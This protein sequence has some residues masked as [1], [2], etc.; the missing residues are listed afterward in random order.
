MVH[1]QTIC[2]LINV[3]WVSCYINM[4][5]K[6]LFTRFFLG[7]SLF[8]LMLFGVVINSARA[9]L[10]LEL[11]DLNLPDLGD[12][13]VFSLSHSEERKR[14]LE[15]LRS[16]RSSGSL[17]EDPEIN[18]WIRSLG[19]RLAARAPQTGNP[20]Y[21][22]VSKDKSINAFAT[23]GGVVLI[24]AGLIIRTDTESELAA[25]LSHE[26]AHVTQRHIARMIAKSKEDTFGRSA[27]I[28]AGI[29]AG[30]QNPEVGQAIIS[31][32]IAAGIQQQ[33]TFN[34][35]A[36]SEADRVG[37]R[38]LASSGFNPLGMPGF[39]EKLEQLS[40]DK[41]SE[42]TEYLRTHPLPHKRVV[43]T[44]FR[45]N[46]IGNRPVKDSANY[47]YMREKVRALVR[48]GSPAASSIPSKVKNYTNALNL[49]KRGL[50]A[51]ALKVMGRQSRQPSEVALIARLLNRQ[52]Q[53]Q[54][55]V[56]L[57]NPLLKIYPGNEAL[58]LL[59]ARAY[60][61]QGQ[62]EQAWNA[63]K[64]VALTEQTSLEFLE[65]RKQIANR[66]GHRA[67]AYR[68]VAERNIRMGEYKYAAIQLRQLMKLPGVNQ[69]DLLRFQRLLADVEKRQKDKKKR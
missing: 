43:D 7:F 10:N 29:V 6:C 57:I 51:Q 38:I 33:L 18:T 49:E 61:S 64:A 8:S 5:N 13:S 39:L 59:L 31:T 20:F 40:D 4:K 9:D 65:I 53:S 52:G 66:A 17:I 36:E 68:S 35:E 58:S 54:A 47:Q 56:K 15:I 1:F 63:I 62:R 25:V 60:E 34:R 48:P 16:L 30:S 14:G 21:F 50:Y 44:Q 32:A 45:A 3:T 37:L 27:A 23:I 41:Y 28:L 69:A 46:R 11:P 19:N 24:N 2:E 42:I 22:V 26:I 67:E 55:A 12:P